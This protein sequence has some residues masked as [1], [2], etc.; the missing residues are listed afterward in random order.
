M[1][2]IVTICEHDEA[3]SIFYDQEWKLTLGCE[4][5]HVGY[6]HDTLLKWA[7]ALARGKVAPS[8]VWHLILGGIVTWYSDS[9]GVESSASVDANSDEEE[10]GE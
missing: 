1:K 10:E 2:T 7:R 5:A 4:E 3:V 6:V 9:P 8:P